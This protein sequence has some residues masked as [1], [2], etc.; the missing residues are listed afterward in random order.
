[1]S[2]QVPGSGVKLALWRAAGWSP[3]GWPLPSG[4][5]ATPLLRKGPLLL[6]AA[7]VPHLHSKAR[8]NSP[9][10][11]SPRGIATPFP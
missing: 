6:T 10:S 1:M 11:P 8:I 9:R 4:T 7:A 2:E 3:Q 5:S